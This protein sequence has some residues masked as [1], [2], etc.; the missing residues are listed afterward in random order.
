MNSIKLKQP[1]LSYL[2]L[3]AEKVN[4]QLSV[5]ELVEEALKNN[6]GTLSSSG[7]LA[8]DTGK[9]T[10]RSPKDRFIVSDYRI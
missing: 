8:V 5:P 7:A 1:D 2:N 3:D 6:E 4:Y 9:F 10:G